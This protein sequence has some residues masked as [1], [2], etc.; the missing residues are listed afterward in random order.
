MIDGPT[1]SQDA[2]YRRGVV[3]GLT[4][5][6]A[7]LL[8]LFCLLLILAVPLIQ[9]AE[10]NRALRAEID[11]IELVRDAVV[12]ERD[13]VRNELAT[14][15]EIARR[16]E[17]ANPGR[18][19]EDI[20]KEY[21]LLLNRIRDLEQQLAAREKAA[22]AFNQIAKAMQDGKPDRLPV[23]EA[24]AVKQ[25]LEERELSKAIADVVAEITATPV[26]NPRKQDVLA[27]LR[28]MGLDTKKAQ[29]VDVKQNELIER[30]SKAEVELARAQ[31][32]LANTLG[33]MENLRKQLRD[34]GR[35]VEAVPCWSKPD[36]KPDYIFDVALTSKG[37]ILRDRK[38]P[39]RAD[40]QKGLPLEAIEFDSEVSTRRFLTM[41]QALYNW[42]TKKECR[43][44]VRA[45]D[46]TSETEK[47]V[48]KQHLRIVDTHFYKYE[49]LNEAY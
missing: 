27:S 7:V 13:R 44:F 10:Q 46:K 36:G 21:A 48:Y 11:R 47:A 18:G 41:T 8:L 4:L 37:L 49:E 35:G 3:L 23:N 22:E 40:E 14:L 25:I 31:V 42:S 29:L 1:S 45:F 28:Q 33:Q 15:Q 2:S 5:G 34:G 43:F 26:S 32:E 19:I 16:F 6:E 30:V 17:L 12:S 24:E 39:H 9:Q 20:T 38:L